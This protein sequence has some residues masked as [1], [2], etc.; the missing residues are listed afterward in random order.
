MK[1]LK[2]VVSLFYEHS[3]ILYALLTVLWFFAI[4]FKPIYQA[5]Q[6]SY[7]TN[8]SRFI[9]VWCNV[10]GVFRWDSDL[11]GLIL[12]ALGAVTLLFVLAHRWARKLLTI[13]TKP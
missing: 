7:A 9:W 8:H 6:F 13:N 3:K 11:H 10:D 12:M 5:W 1:K 2:G 4:L